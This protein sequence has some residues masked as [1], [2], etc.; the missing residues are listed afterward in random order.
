MKFYHPFTTVET[1]AQRGEIP[2]LGALG[3][4]L[5]GLDCKCHA[6]SLTQR[7]QQVTCPHKVTE[8]GGD[9]AISVCMR[10]S[11]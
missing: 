2:G 9:G 11:L 1:E 8:L 7:P 3:L 4:N 6:Q 5:G 10:P